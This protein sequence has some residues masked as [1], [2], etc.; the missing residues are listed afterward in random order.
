MILCSNFSI[1]MKNKLV[2]NVTPSKLVYHLFF[3]FCFS[4]KK[5]INVVSYASLLKDK[6]YA[7]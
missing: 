2:T 5:F 3:I 7:H 4:T 1:H 6:K